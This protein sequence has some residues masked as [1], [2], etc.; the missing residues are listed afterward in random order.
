MC[1]VTTFSDAGKRVHAAQYVRM[2]TDHQQYSPENQK[3]ALADYARVHDIDI[4]ETY[5][6]D[7]RSGVTLRHRPALLKLLKDVLDPG[8][9]FETVL[10][11][12]VS[13]WGR[14]QDVDE[15][16][17][18]EYICRQAGVSVIYC[19]EPFTNDG[20]P[21]SNIIKTVK[22]AMAGEYSRELSEKVFLGQSRHVERGFWLGAPPGFGL[23]RMLVD[24]NGT[25]KS[26]LKTAEHKS[27]RADHTILVPG[28]ANETALVRAIFSW[29]VHDKLGTGRIAER[30]NDF[31]L[32]NSYG[33]PWRSGTIRLLLRNEKYVGNLVW[34]R[35]SIKLHTPL[36]RNDPSKWYRHIGA[37]SPIVD[38][39]LFEA[40]QKRLGRFRIKPDTEAIA[41]SMARLL[42]SSG[43]LS[44]RSIK[45]ELDIP[46][47]STVRRRMTSL[48]EGYRLAGYNS[49]RDIAYVDER[50]IAKKS[51]ATHISDLIE[52]LRAQGHLVE[53]NEIRPSLV[54]DR[55]LRIKVAVSLGQKDNTFRPY[56]QVIKSSVKSADLCLVGYYPRPGIHLLGFYLLPGSVIADKG[57]TTLCES[58]IP[59]VEGFRMSDLSAVLTLCAHAP[60]G[61]LP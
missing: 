44:V 57:M 13:R 34:N 23:R 33:N 54:I 4:V 50:V 48:E 16:A 26:Y 32:Y 25:S 22:R 53:Y 15:S 46:G 36:I 43:T 6:D 55:Y 29:Y 41:A 61:G 42:R 9:A 8:R 24:A 12:D 38:R 52:R 56:A 31:G 45:S 30:L 49:P 7:G 11:Y 59:G 1:P 18:H 3:T 19:A 37:F 60:L 10:V 39:E 14:F 2:S 40:A 21:A 28:P 58:Q 27:I 35:T 5:E 47:K 17:H 20:T 51:M